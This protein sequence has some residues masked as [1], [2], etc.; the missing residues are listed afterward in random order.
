MSFF[1]RV[2]QR[3]CKHRYSDAGLCMY[4]VG[5]YC[6]YINHCTKCGKRT[7]LS[8]ADSKIFG[9]NQDENKDSR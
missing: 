2:K 9:G 4:R 7:G 8:I 6:V 3:L 1:A 5:G